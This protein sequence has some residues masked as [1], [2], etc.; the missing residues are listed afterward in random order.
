MTQTVLALVGIGIAMLTDWRYRKIPNALTL[1]LIPLGIILN[2]SDYGWK[3]L[4]MGMLGFGLGIALLYVPFRLG[5]VGGGDV[6]LMGALGS[7]LGPGIIFKIFLASAIFGGLMSLA[8]VIKRKALKQIWNA[9]KIQ[10]VY[11]FLTRKMLSQ[12]N[13]SAAGKSL[14]IPYSFAIGCGILFVLF[15]MQGG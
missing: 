1:S 8:L 3:G 2:V 14:S 13:E 6:K 12:Q 15:L 4:E 10:M 7:L 9:M 5:G 11:L